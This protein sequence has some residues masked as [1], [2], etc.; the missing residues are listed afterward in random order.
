MGNLKLGNYGHML[1]FFVF[2]FSS[3]SGQIENTKKQQIRG[4]GGGIC[5]MGIL[6]QRLIEAANLVRLCAKPIR[7]G[8]M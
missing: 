3:F 5:T 6:P 8:C 4:I 7:L 1:S 2:I